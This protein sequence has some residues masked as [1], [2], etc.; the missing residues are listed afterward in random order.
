[1]YFRDDT[2]QLKHQYLHSVYEHVKALA[3][4]V[5]QYEKGMFHLKM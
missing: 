4:L 2:S 1:M 5:N 3:E